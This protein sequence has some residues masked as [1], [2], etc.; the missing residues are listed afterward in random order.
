[1]ARIENPCHQKQ[2]Y[3]PHKHFTLTRVPLNTKMEFSGSTS[4]STL[5]RLC[6]GIRPVGLVFQEGGTWIVSP[7][8]Q[9]WLDTGDDLYLTAI[10]CANVRFVGELLGQLEEPRI[11]AELLRIAREEYELSWETTSEINNRC[12]SI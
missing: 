9:R 1:M 11:M 6:I 8:G 3:S 12:L 4:E 10:F 2:V 5:D 7:E